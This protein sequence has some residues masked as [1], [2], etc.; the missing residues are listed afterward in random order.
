MLIKCP[1][2]Y[3]VTTHGAMY[4]HVLTLPYARGFYFVGEKSW[5][6][7]GYT[8]DVSLV[9]KNSLTLD[10]V[11]TNVFTNLIFH[12]LAEIQY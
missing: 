1:T 4:H 7:V 9:E 6:L 11:N 10:R 8:Q 12:C 3:K 2:L 5:M